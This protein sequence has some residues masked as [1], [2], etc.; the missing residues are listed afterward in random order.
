MALIRSCTTQY[1][2]TECSDLYHSGLKGIISY[3][4]KISNK[5]ITDEFAVKQRQKFQNYG[6]SL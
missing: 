5:K 2:T 6:T 1:N 4:D 3:R